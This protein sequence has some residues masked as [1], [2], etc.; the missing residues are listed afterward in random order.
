VTDQPYKEGLMAELQEL[1]VQVKHLESLI[2]VM[3]RNEVLK[4]RAP[5]H[6][7]TSEIE[8]IGDFDIIEA[9]GV[10]ISESGICFDLKKPLYFDMRFPYKGDTIE[11]YARLIWVKQTN[12]GL[13]RLGFQFEDPGSRLVI[14]RTES[15][16]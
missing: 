6:P 10:D 4:T 13:A 2:R 11:K 14:Q 1:R 5:R 12:E 7:L 8:L 3:A 15:T 9:S 16:T